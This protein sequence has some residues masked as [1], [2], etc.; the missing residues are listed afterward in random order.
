MGSRMS[1]ANADFATAM[2][3]TYNTPFFTVRPSNG[4]AGAYPICHVGNRSAKARNSAEIFPRNAESVFLYTRRGH[5][6]PESSTKRFISRAAVCWELWRVSVSK[7][8]TDVTPAGS[9]LADTSDCIPTAQNFAP[10]S[11]APVRSSASARMHIRLLQQVHG[12]STHS[13]SRQISPGFSDCRT[14]QAQ[15]ASKFELHRQ[16]NLPRFRIKCRHRDYAEGCRIEG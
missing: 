15:R 9:G 14:E 16:L 10:T 13:I 6:A 2:P 1:C 8:T 12:R 4:Y 11:R 3:S 5:R 7:T